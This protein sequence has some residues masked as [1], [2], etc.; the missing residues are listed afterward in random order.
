MMIK[1]KKGDWS[2][3]KLASIALIIIVMIL[4]LIAFPNMFNPLVK[5]IKEKGNAWLDDHDNDDIIDAL[6]ECPCKFAFANDYGQKG[7]PKIYTE[8]QIIAD[9][10]TFKENKCSTASSTVSGAQTSGTPAS[11]TPPVAALIKTIIYLYEQDTFI[12]KDDNGNNIFLTT[13]KDIKFYVSSPSNW[14]VKFLRPGQTIPSGGEEREFTSL[15]TISYDISSDGVYEICFKN[16][17]ENK[18]IDFK[19]VPLFYLLDDNQKMVEGDI[20]TTTQNIGWYHLTCAPYCN[21]EVKYVDGKKAE[22]HYD[23]GSAKNYYV[24]LDKVGSYSV[25][26]TGIAYHKCKTIIKK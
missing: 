8:E 12:S 25:C 11:G 2:V 3:Q 5:G 24:P 19:K 6:D 9:K 7:C 21:V 1:N 14:S 23:K 16:K 15:T 18:C 10:K 20:F 17:E 4:L 13:K 22:E 26:L